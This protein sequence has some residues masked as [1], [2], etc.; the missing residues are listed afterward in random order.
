MY[1]E[2]NKSF[3]KIRNFLL[4]VLNKKNWARNTCPNKVD[5]DK[6]YI[7]LTDIRMIMDFKFKSN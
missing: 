4:K 5:T 3:K 7:N 1:R 6:I 2:V